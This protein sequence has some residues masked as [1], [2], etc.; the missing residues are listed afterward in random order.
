MPVDFK[1]CTSNGYAFINL[2]N[3]DQSNF[4]HVPF[5]MPGR[6]YQ[7]VSVV[8]SCRLELD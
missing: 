8:S 1:D 6:A 2:L 3:P 4:E 5:S 7:D